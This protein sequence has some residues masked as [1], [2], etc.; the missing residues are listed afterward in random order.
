MQRRRISQ[1]N[2]HPW[3]SPQDFHCDHQE[4]EQSSQHVHPSTSLHVH[5]SKPH[6]PQQ[7]N[8]ASTPL[9][10]PKYKTKHT[11]VDDDPFPV[12]KLLWSQHVDHTP[13]STHSL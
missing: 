2:H 4:L 10:S 13:S 1:V 8:S 11:N 3:Y 9:P 5:S 6:P 7:V 12:H